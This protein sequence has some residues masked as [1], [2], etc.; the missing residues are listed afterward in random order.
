MGWHIMTPSLHRAGIKKQAGC[1]SKTL[2]AS[3]KTVFGVGLT[4]VWLWEWVK[5]E[6]FVCV[7]NWKGLAC[8]DAHSGWLLPLCVLSQD[9]TGFGGC[10]LYW[11]LLCLLCCREL[12]QG[13]QVGK[14]TTAGIPPPPPTPPRRKACRSW[15]GLGYACRVQKPQKLTE[16][17][18]KLFLSGGLLWGKLSGQAS[19]RLIV[20]SHP[21]NRPTA[22]TASGVYLHLLAWRWTLLPLRGRQFWLPSCGLA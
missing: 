21:T 13:T 9:L 6:L 7:G 5:S 17:L 15:K 19:F 22:C 1:S 12:P 4:C 16:V 14:W 8:K 2:K 10:T 20:A 3:S 18:R 11:W